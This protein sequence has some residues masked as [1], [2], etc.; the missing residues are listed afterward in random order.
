MKTQASAKPELDPIGQTDDVP[1]SAPDRCFN[2]VLPRSLEQI[3]FSQDGVCS[4]CRHAAL[5]SDRS[6]DAHTP[7]PI[8]S[9][10]ERIRVM[11]YGRPYDCLVGLSGG[12]DSS[13]LLYL[14]VKKHGLR[15]LAAYYRTPFT[16]DVIDANV[17]RMAQ[18]LG[19]K[20]IRISLSWRKHMD[21]ARRCVLLWRKSPSLELTNLACVRCKMVNR[22]VH[23]IARD[24]RIGAII[25]GGNKHELV[26]FVPSYTDK[27]NVAAGRAFWTQTQRLLKVSAR[28][29]LLLARTPSVLSLVPTS[30]APALLY[31]DFHTSFLRLRYAGINRVDYFHHAVLSEAEANATVQEELGWRLPPDCTTTWRADC[32]FAEVKNYMYEKVCGATY[33]DGFFS[34]LIR[35]GLMSREEAVA[36]LRN[37]S[38]I[39]RPRVIRALEVLGLS[40]STLPAS[41]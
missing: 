21:A 14:L 16:H 35:A 27:A 5:R 10:M 34:N 31:M 26:Q 13:Y 36:K 24:H 20:L 7:E 22:Q 15:V 18:R 37:G 28:G 4:L 23:R 8:E 12:R 30:L 41:D 17:T 11:G 38:Y 2:C 6:P 40:G 33:T 3:S 25:Y 39:S 32:D 9:V 29:L 19:V 1:V